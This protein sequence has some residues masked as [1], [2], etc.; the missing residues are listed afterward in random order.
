MKLL[1]FFVAGIIQTIF[2]V[3]II[4][5][6]AKEKAAS[7]AVVTF[8]S[9]LIQLGVLVS[10]LSSLQSG[11]ANIVVY[12]AGIAMGAYLGIKLKLEKTKG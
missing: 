9:S 2:Q 1:L 5:Y 11:M 8:F 4:R 3:V 10:I 6:V 12:S 7:A